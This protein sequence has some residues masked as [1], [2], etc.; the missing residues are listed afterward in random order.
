MPGSMCCLLVEPAHWARV[1]EAGIAGSSCRRG[2]SENGVAA[3]CTHTNM[4]R[5][6][7]RERCTYDTHHAVGEQ[8]GDTGC[9]VRQNSAS[10]GLKVL[11]LGP[12]DQGWTR[13]PNAGPPRVLRGHGDLFK[14]R[15][16]IGPLR[17]GGV[18]PRYGIPTPRIG[19]EAPPSSVTSCI[20]WHRR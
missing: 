17:P 9:R 4:E 13:L 18:A 20:G 15:Q 8:W 14:L 6:G 12:R 11:D 7:G 1:P 10:T 2:C 5:E 19:R 16:R 3:A